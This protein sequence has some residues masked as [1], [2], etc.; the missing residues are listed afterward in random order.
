MDFKEAMI[1]ELVTEYDVFEV[2]KLKHEV[3]RLRNSVWYYKRLTERLRHQRRMRRKA[4]EHCRTRLFINLS[5]SETDS[6]Q[7]DTD[8]SE[9]EWNDLL[10]NE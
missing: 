3:E 2:S 8:E 10:F 5:F 9:Q 4:M 6:D 1:R 7:T